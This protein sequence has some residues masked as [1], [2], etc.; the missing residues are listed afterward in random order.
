MKIFA[1]SILISSLSAIA[2]N[3]YDSDEYVTE[4]EITKEKTE[5]LERKPN[6]NK[7]SNSMLISYSDARIQNAKNKD[8][9]NTRASKCISSVENETGYKCLN[10]DLTYFKAYR[11]CNLTYETNKKAST[12]SETATLLEVREACFSAA[13][14]VRKEVFNLDQCKDYKPIR[15]ID[16]HTNYFKT[17]FDLI[18]SGKSAPG[19]YD[20]ITASSELSSVN[21]IKQKFMKC[22]RQAWFDTKHETY[23]INSYENVA[24][25]YT[26]KS[27]GKCIWNP[28]R[29][30]F[31]CVYNRNQLTYIHPNGSMSVVTD[32]MT[33]EKKESAINQYG[34]S[35]AYADV[36][37]NSENY[38][39]LYDDLNNSIADSAG[40]IMF[41]LDTDAKF[42]SGILEYYIFNDSNADYIAAYEANKSLKWRSQ[43]SGQVSWLKTGPKLKAKIQSILAKE[44]GSVIWSYIFE[45]DN[46]YL[47]II[48]DFINNRK[49]VTEKY[50]LSSYTID[51]YPNG[52]EM[53][54]EN[55]A[56]EVTTTE[57]ASTTT[58][59]ESSDL[60]KSESIDEE[61]SSS[62]NTVIEF[63]PALS[64][65]EIAK[66]TPNEKEAMIQ[67]QGCGGTG[68]GS[69][70]L[71]S[72][73]AEKDQL[74]DNLNSE[75]VKEKCTSNDNSGCNTPALLE[76]ML[77]YRTKYKELNDEVQT[78]ESEG[79]VKNPKTCRVLFFNTTSEN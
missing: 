39:P 71:Y 74:L 61:T 32:K 20:N 30:R 50:L 62:S 45:S 54:E 2:G 5:Y 8:L 24:D 40:K 38:F 46:L 64:P 37:K 7:C 68:S 34:R 48:G 4:A 69:K 70:S 53:S 11:R 66:F 76:T 43:D 28:V 55:L 44:K 77:V 27:L 26:R 65:I 25:C 15:D 78:W 56:T 22:Y 49:V 52:I 1:I 73:A 36:T 41:T 21:K 10:A 29:G 3:Y 9:F 17:T 33:S 59:S 47:E 13:E 51:G 72:Y 79:N 18:I 42:V 19:A 6:A 12:D 16:S 75:L 57:V 63:A 14:K 60:S 31:R 35:F 23:T 67:D 58:S